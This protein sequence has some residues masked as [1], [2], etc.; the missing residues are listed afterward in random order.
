MTQEQKIMERM[1]QESREMDHG[2]VTPRDEIEQ[3]VVNYMIRVH[4]LH[5]KALKVLNS[6]VTADTITL[7][8]AERSIFWLKRAYPERTFAEWTSLPTVEEYESWERGM[9]DHVSMSHK[10]LLRK[11]WASYQNSISWWWIRW[12]CPWR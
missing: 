2:L 5:H 11:C 9:P 6:F 10:K 12:L 7:Y 3:T 8:D 4:T 1:F